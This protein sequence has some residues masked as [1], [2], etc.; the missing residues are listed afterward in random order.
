MKN[1]NLSGDNMLTEKQVMET[2]TEFEETEIRFKELHKNF[3]EEDIL[4]DF[5]RDFCGFNDFSKKIEEEIFWYSPIAEFKYPRII[6]L[7]ERVI[8][9]NG[10]YHLPFLHLHEF[11][12]IV[13]VLKGKCM[14]TV[15]GTRLIS[16]EGDLCYIAPGNVHSIYN[17]D[18][19]GIVLNLCVSEENMK[20]VLS[21][22]ENTNNRVTKN[23]S[24]LLSSAKC[25]YISFSDRYDFM[26]NE[27]IKTLMLTDM[28]LTGTNQLIVALLTEIF[29]FAEIENIPVAVGESTQIPEKDV[30]DLVNTIRENHKDLTLKSLSEKFHYTP[31]YMSKLIRKETGKTFKELVNGFKVAEACEL[32]KTTELRV[33]DIAYEV[34]FNSVEHFIRTFKQFTKINPIEYRKIKKHQ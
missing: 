33:I 29:S 8:R 10:R 23:I 3:S 4:E 7:N 20:T 14:Q 25:S 32:L 1:I 30:Y 27:I 22:F 5:E 31:Q 18:D 26:K 2:L 34:G 17:N 19:D 15:N 28:S 11:H 13:F 6:K 12:E 9:K 21:L 16:R 24:S